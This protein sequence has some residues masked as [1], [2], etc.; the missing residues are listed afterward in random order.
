MRTYLHIQ[1]I[2]LIYQDTKK[3]FA[4]NV[5]QIFFLITMMA[6]AFEYMALEFKPKNLFSK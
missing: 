3:Y 1:S 2:S 6:S 4:F 5:P